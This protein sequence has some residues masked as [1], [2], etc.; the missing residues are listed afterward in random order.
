MLLCHTSSL[1]ECGAVLFLHDGSSNVGVF[2]FL[3]KKSRFSA[4]LG[5]PLD[6]TSLPPRGL[7]FSGINRE[8]RRRINFFPVR[9]E[10]RHLSNVCLSL[11]SF[12]VLRRLRQPRYLSTFKG[13]E[14]T[15]GLFRHVPRREEYH[16]K[17]CCSL[18]KGRADRG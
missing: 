7:T 6:T 4:I 1:L 9:T 2:Q 18:Y 12:L 11:K 10:R 5:W 16:K 14:I 13:H 15:P 3:P 17:G 8:P